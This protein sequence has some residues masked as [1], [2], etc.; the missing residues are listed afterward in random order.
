MCICWRNKSDDPLLGCLRQRNLLK[1]EYGTFV[2]HT[3]TW[4]ASRLPQPLTQR[5]KMACISIAQKVVEDEP[6]TRWDLFPGL[7]HRD[8]Q[9]VEWRVLSLLDFR[10]TP[11]AH[12]ECGARAACPWA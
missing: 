3:A 5:E 7:S 6:L 11:S 4:Y 2:L 12:R 9:T 1:R 8:L 10:I